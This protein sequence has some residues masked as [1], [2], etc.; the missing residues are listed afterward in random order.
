MKTDEIRFFDPSENAESKPKKRT[1]KLVELTG[2]ISGVGKLVLPNKTVDQ[3]GIDPA[4]MSFKIGAQAGKRKAKQL[5]LMPT[6]STD[7][8]AFAM[9]KSAKSYTVSLPVI[10]Q[11][12]GVDF[13]KQKYKFVIEPYD[14]DG[15]DGYALVLSKAAAKTTPKPARTSTGTGRVG[16]P[17]GSGKKV[18]Q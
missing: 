3:L 5:Y 17:K 4:G 18:A 15:T 10:L 8:A 12:N 2:Y 13:A 9:E 16:R 11:R 1:K 14:F 6:S 7:S